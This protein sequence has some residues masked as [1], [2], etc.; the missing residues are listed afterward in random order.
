[1]IARGEPPPP[2]NI[3][4]CFSSVPDGRQTNANFVPQFPRYAGHVPHPGGEH[5]RF[6]FPRTDEKLMARAAR[7][8]P[9]NS[10][11]FSSPFFIAAHR[12]SRFFFLRSRARPPR[13]TPSVRARH[14]TRQI[15]LFDAPWRS[16]PTIGLPGH[17]GQVI[18]KP[19]RARRRK[20]VLA[21]KSFR[22]RRRS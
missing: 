22:R 14:D 11:T 10:R 8:D 21:P 4:L 6:C 18:R 5:Y 3:L 16:T 17:P 15:A 7:S 20:S 13:S 9:T 2:C 1:M 19:L 12:F